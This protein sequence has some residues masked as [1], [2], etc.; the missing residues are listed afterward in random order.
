MC[1][2]LFLYI[3]NSNVSAMKKISSHGFM[4]ENVIEWL[5]RSMISTQSID[6]LGYKN[7]QGIYKLCSSS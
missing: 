2:S 3:E 1:D 7:S 4:C 6:C 5:I